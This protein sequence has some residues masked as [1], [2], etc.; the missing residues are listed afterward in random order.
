MRFDLHAA[1]CGMVPDPVAF[2]L[3]PPLVTG[4]S[5]EVFP[6]ELPQEARPPSCFSNWDD[7]LSAAVTKRRG[8]LDSTRRRRWSGA[9]EVDPMVSLAGGRY[10][11]VS[12]AQPALV[13]V[14]A[15]R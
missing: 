5:S 15:L 14:A 10:G 13:A 3:A 12:G 8:G 11:D 9:R 7:V 6:R 1:A 2:G 4:T